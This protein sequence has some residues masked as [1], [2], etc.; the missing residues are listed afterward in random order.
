MNPILSY[1]IVGA[2]ILALARAAYTHLNQG[3]RTHRS[4]LTPIKI[5]DIEINNNSPTNAP[6]INSLIAPRVEYLIENEPFPQSENDYMDDGR[7]EIII[8]IDTLKETNIE[9][10]SIRQRTKEKV[11]E[12]EKLILLIK[13]LSDKYK[14]DLDEES[15]D[16][17]LDGL[18]LLELDARQSSLLELYNHL[19]QLSFEEEVQQIRHREQLMQKENNDFNNSSMNDEMTALTNELESLRNEEILYRDIRSATTLEFL[20]GLDLSNFSEDSQTRLQSHY[21]FY[22]SRLSEKIRIENETNNYRKY[23]DLILNSESRDELD[24]LTIEGVNNKQLH[25]LNDI[26]K[27][28][29]EILDIRQKQLKEDAMA[30]EI[31]L[32]IESAESTKELDLI[33]ITGVNS[34]QEEELNN[35]FNVTREHL[36]FNELVSQISYSQYVL[37]LD[38]LVIEGVNEERHEE[39]LTL[40]SNRRMELVEIAKQ[41]K[42]TA[43]Y[44]KFLDELPR[45]DEIDELLGIEIDNVSEEQKQELEALR[46]SRLDYLE[47]IERQRIEREQALQFTNLRKQIESSKTTTEIDKIIIEGVNDQQLEELN[48]IKQEVR[49]IIAEDEEITEQVKKAEKR[50]KKH[51]GPEVFSIDPE[52]EFRTRSKSYE[53][54]DGLLR[55]SLCWNNMNDLD[56][57]VKTPKGEIIHRAKRKSSCGGQLDL[58]MNSQPQSKSALENIVWL[59]EKTPP[60]GAYNV[61]IWH[62]KRHQKLRKSDPTNYTLRVRVG[63]DYYQYIGQTS[64]GDKL[65]QIATIDVPDKTTLF[66]RLES[67]LEIYRNQRT[68][69]LEVQNENDFP[70]INKNNSDIHVI[71]LE[72]LIEKQRAQLEEKKQKEFIAKQKESYDKIINTIQSAENIDELLEIRYD[73]LSPDAQKSVEK[74]LMKRKKAIESGIIKT[75]QKEQLMLFEEQRTSI[76]NSQNIT[77]LSSIIFDESLTIKQKTSLQ[78]MKS[79]KRKLLLSKMNPEELEEEKQSRLHQALNQSYKRGGLQPLNIDETTPNEFN[80]RLKTNS[81]KSGEPQISILWNNKNDLNLLVVT[82]NKEVIHPRNPKSSEGGIL[83]LEMNKKGESSTPVENIYWKKG[84]AIKGTYYIYV[85]LF[86][87]HSL[88]KKTNLSECRIQ[89]NNKGKTNEYLAQ[90]STQNKLQFVT[91]MKID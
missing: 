54:L 33:V 1:L 3:S 78:K 77:E 91:Q 72:R 70:E 35:L 39:L 31:K 53:A 68:D 65:K 6:T 48:E 61:F 14:I 26:L 42:F 55:F 18:T 32:K 19:Y 82:P 28:R 36:K 11:S 44:N 12:C 20:E 83:D 2:T 4:L 46:L 87:E 40:K 67:E 38:N 47:E 80:E 81:A 64:Y 37:E 56:L 50:R 90:L 17:Q 79:A 23:K 88:F 75:K 71:M 63:A 57:I 52:S 25:H 49:D 62:R 76:N 73:K 51:S 58:E 22:Y 85:H 15:I 60:E 89:V 10:Y 43:Q 84:N 8:E 59:K 74:Q 24:E 21:E 16:S 34:T 45:I 27:K 5:E 86:K 13:G 69:I 9:R 7:D 29:I 66:E 30:E 41:K